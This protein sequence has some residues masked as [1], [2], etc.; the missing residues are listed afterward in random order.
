M[1]PQTGLHTGP[2]TEVPMSVSFTG[3]WISAPDFFLSARPGEP[4]YLLYICDLT[5]NRIIEDQA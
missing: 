4:F 2:P 3:K 5:K 1:N